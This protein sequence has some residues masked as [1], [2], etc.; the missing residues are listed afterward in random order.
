M[1]YQGTTPLWHSNTFQAAAPGI[2]S[3]T[4]YTVSAWVKLNG[5]TGTDQSVICQQGDNVPS[6]NLFYREASRSWDVMTTSQDSSA[7][8]WISVGASGGSAYPGAWTHIAATYSADTEVLAFYVNGGQVG[9]AR[10]PSPW[11][12]ATAPERRGSPPAP[13]AP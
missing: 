9:S 13:A 10:M 8:H 11:V 1:V 7:A 5:S 2:V 4:G 3:D 6:V 12:A